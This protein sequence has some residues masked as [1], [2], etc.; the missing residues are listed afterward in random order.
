MSNLA[1]EKFSP[2]WFPVK[3]SLKC[4]SIVLLKKPRVKSPLD[5]P[6]DGVLEAS[7]DIMDLALELQSPGVVLLLTDLSNS[8]W[9][10]NLSGPLIYKMRGLACVVS[11]EFSGSKSHSVSA[12]Y[13]FLT[14]PK[15]LL[16]LPNCYLF[17]TDF[18]LP[19]SPSYDSF[20]PLRD[21]S[22]N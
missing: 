3:V 7:W 10:N 1:P 9:L 18:I 12:E 15:L 17:S 22:P 2:L 19:T 20:F 14:S 5:W 6:S 21:N 4:W 8:V 13:L 11:Q 16:S